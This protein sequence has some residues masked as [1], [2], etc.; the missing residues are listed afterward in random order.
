MGKIHLLTHDYWMIF[1]EE[2][3]FRII[4]FNSIVI[5]HLFLF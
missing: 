2:L 5:K 3:N 4:Y 1:D